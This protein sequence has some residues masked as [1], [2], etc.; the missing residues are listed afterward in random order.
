MTTDQ[1]KYGISSCYE[2]K[3]LK[4]KKPPQEFHMYINSRYIFNA[5]G[6][7]RFKVGFHETTLFY[8]SFSDSSIESG[9][10]ISGGI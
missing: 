3:A 6:I 9:M 10:T 7:P 1:Q 2:V 4:G 8:F 5:M